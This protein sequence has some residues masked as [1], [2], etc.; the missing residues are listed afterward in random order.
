[1]IILFR[2][3]KK[4]SI[5]L[6]RYD[7]VGKYKLSIITT[8][9]KLY[10]KDL[11]IEITRRCNMSCTHCMRGDIQNVDIDHRHIKSLLKHFQHIQ[12]LNITG[13]E[14]SLNVKAIRYILKQLKLYNIHVYSIYIV[15]NGSL[16]SISKEFIDICSELYEYQE[17]EDGYSHM[18]EMSDDKFH[19]N[20][21]HQ[22]VIATLMQYPF[23]GLRNQAK[24]IFLFKEGRS[25]TGYPN[26][27]HGI[28][29]TSENYVYGDI[30]LNAA[31]NVI[32]NGNLSYQRQ[33]EN[34]LCSSTD[35]LKYIK[36]TLRT[37]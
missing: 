8:M 11:C 17:E 6:E 25:T 29:L 18:L 12:H 19:N 34:I 13:G 28:Y 15:T 10:A 7:K 30:Y 27:V 24:E 31:G 33:Q 35:F 32:G 5:P 14:P 2:E 3:Q 9:N 20:Q 26:P 16:S 37:E 21:Y 36:S 22:K 23:F 4:Q 1:M